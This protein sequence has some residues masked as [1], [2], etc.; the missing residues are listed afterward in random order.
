MLQ[1]L[2]KRKEQGY[3]AVF[4]QAKR[5][6]LCCNFCTSE[7]NKVMLQFLYNRKEHGY[8]AIFI[9]AKE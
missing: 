1:F 6:R 2:Y 3:A 8:A 9:Q 5:T 7:N 4:V